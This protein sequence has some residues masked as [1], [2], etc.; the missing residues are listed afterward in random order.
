MEA[1]LENARR[2]T[3]EERARATGAVQSV[4]FLQRVEWRAEESGAERVRGEPLGA[5][6]ASMVQP[7]DDLGEATLCAGRRLQSCAAA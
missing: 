3:G 1:L 6:R 2:H 5:A 7:D 4:Q